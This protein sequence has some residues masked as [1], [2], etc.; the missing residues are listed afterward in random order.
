MSGSISVCVLAS[1][2]TGNATLVSSCD[3]HLLVDC[4]LVAKEVEG[5]LTQLGLHPSDL[6]GIIIT[7]AHVD[8]YRSAGT[9]HCRYG[10]PVYTD[11]EADHAI[12]Q[13]NSNGSYYRVKRP[14]QIPA[15]IGS[16]RVDVFATSHTVLGGRPMGFVLS[17]GGARVGIVTDTGSLSSKAIRMLR[18]C[19]VLVVEANYDPDIIRAKLNDPDYTIDWNY[20]R[21]VASGEGHLSNEQCAQLLLETVTRETQHVF[22]AHIS[23]NHRDRRRDNNS[24]E[25]ASQDICRA[26][27]REGLRLP[28][29]HRTY[30]RDA[31]EG[32]PSKLVTV[33]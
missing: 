3:T 15:A 20:L 21:W 25:R 31:T 19:E 29:P 13:R 18:G 14:Q 26:C 32:Q 24:F 22:L 1:G 6:S 11:L 33:D 17:A 28:V 5:R 12:R 30:R 8:H 10:V 7:H 27:R 9:I 23:E 2:S 16:I 4:G